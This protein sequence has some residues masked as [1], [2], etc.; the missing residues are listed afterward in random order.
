MTFVYYL[1]RHLNYYYSYMKNNN[2][3]FINVNMF[4]TWAS[5]FIII[6]AL[7]R[8]LTC[9]TIL[10]SCQL[11]ERVGRSPVMNII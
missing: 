5:F 9:L 4:N 8:T 1:N 10:F 7:K 3:L 11:F 6:H 2:W